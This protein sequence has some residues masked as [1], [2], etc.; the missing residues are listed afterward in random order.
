MMEASAERPA[1]RGTKIPPSVRGQFEGPGVV[2]AARIGEAVRYDHP[3]ARGVVDRGM[4]I[5]P[6]RSRFIGGYLLPG[7]GRDIER[8][9]VAEEAAGLSAE[10]HEAA[11]GWIEHQG[12]TEPR[13]GTL[14]RLDFGPAPLRQRVSPKI[15]LL[16]AVRSTEDKDLPAGGIVRNRT[17]EP[18]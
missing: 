2:K 15:V 17:V 5:S 12:V 14:P 18:G 1:G 3:V 13:R 16:D 11:A 7:S 8:P 6:A 9:R 10:K 4:T